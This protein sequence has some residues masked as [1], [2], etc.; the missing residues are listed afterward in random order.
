MTRAA[1]GITIEK[2]ARGIAWRLN[3]GIR[4]RMGWRDLARKMEVD[5][6]MW[7]AVCH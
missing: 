1:R 7:M 3:V 4:R 2:M 5:E 6:D